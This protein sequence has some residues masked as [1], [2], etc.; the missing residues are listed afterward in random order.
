[1]ID[2]RKFNP[3]RKKKRSR[4]ERKLSLGLLVWVVALGRDAHTHLHSADNGGQKHRY[5]AD[6]M[7][8]PYGR[9]EKIKVEI[10]YIFFELKNSHLISILPPCDPIESQ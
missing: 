1:L 2:S 9:S 7:E 6:K 5:T 4:S 3:P 8:R 10:K